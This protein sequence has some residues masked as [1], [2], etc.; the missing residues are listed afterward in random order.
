[1]VQNADETVFDLDVDFGAFVDVGGEGAL[2]GD[3]EVGAA[4]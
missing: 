2:G 1:L 3:D 4:M